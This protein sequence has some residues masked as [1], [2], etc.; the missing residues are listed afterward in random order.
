[1]EYGQELCSIQAVEGLG[2]VDAHDPGSLCIFFS[3][4][5][6]KLH[7]PY[8]FCGAPALSVCVLADA[9]IEEVTYFLGKSQELGG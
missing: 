8:N 9:L 3:S 2:Q 7:C 1:M 6:D 5:F 4:C